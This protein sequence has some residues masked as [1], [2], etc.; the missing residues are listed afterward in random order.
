MK[1]DIKKDNMAFFTIV[2]VI[3]FAFV[4][5][6]LFLVTFE[7]EKNTHFIY[8]NK[9]EEFEKVLL[10]FENKANNEIKLKAIENEYLSKEKIPLL[11]DYFEGVFSVYDLIDENNLTEINTELIKDENTD[12]GF[13]SDNLNLQLIGTYDDIL[14]FIDDVNNLKF[15]NEILYL[16]IT[17]EELIS[18]DEK[19]L[20]EI[21]IKFFGLADEV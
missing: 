19:L 17:S 14:N 2:L 1:F 5:Q 21:Y 15:Y 20:L 8:I 16:N 10:N 7:E 4:L 13:T 12:E 6:K 3:L 11:N 18:N 9:K